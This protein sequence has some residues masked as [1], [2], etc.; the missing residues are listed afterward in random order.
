M[1]LRHLCFGYSIMFTPRGEQDGL[2]A[3]GRQSR[4]R[5]YA[6][7]AWLR[8]LLLPVAVL[9]GAINAHAAHAQA[10]ACASEA[11]PSEQLGQLFRDVQLSG[12]FA[13]G[14]TFADLQ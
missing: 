3:P 12:I 14:K 13:D 1:S 4:R 6:S 9:G 11:A 2:R 7:P 10:P 5:S 8:V